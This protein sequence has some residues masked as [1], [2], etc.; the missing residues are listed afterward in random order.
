MIEA[1]LAPP[2]EPEPAKFAESPKWLESPPQVSPVFES[3]PR[4]DEIVF[5]VQAAPEL[6]PHWIGKQEPEPHRERPRWEPP[7]ERPRWTA[8][9]RV[10]APKWSPSKTKQL[11]D[12][13]SLE[14]RRMQRGSLEIEEVLR[15]RILRSEQEAGAPS[16]PE[17]VEEEMLAEALGLAQPQAPS[18]LEI[19]SA[20]QAEARKAFWFRVNAELIIYGSTEPD[21]HV[22][23]GGRPIRLRPDGS[24]SYRFALPDG[25]Y[26]LPVVAIARDGHDGRAAELR[27]SRASRY[28]GEVRPHP[29][30]PSLKAP[31]AENL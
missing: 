2:S 9:K 5:A 8:P 29:Q 27:F 7:K 16:S 17:W 20:P 12:L 21:A 6:A 24:F 19:A 3:Q 4:K 15:R 18:S 10:A 13:I 11:D 28:T 23:I 22:S 31:A 26:E 25:A 30:D 14:F 1:P